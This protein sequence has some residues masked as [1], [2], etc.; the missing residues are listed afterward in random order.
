MDEPVV[1][2]IEEQRVGTPKL[3]DAIRVGLTTIKEARLSYL[4]PWCGC[5]IGLAAVGLGH[6]AKLTHWDPLF[7]YVGQHTGLSHDFLRDVENRHVS[8][9]SA[10]EIADWLE[11]RGY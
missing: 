6:E 10:L 7:D 1:N 3:S 5:A 11:A 4:T 2:V 8:G 9:A